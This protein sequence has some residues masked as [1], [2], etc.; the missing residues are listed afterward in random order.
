MRAGAVA[1]GY[2]K[3]LGSGCKEASVIGRGLAGGVVATDI[4]LL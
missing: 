2:W 4:V 3:M 1:E